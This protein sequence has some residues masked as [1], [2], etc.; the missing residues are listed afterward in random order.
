M[1]YSLKNEILKHFV[2]V[3]EKKYAGVYCFNKQNRIIAAIVAM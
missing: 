1:Q 2:I 3:K